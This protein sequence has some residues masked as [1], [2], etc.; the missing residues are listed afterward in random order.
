MRP[1]QKRGTRVNFITHIIYD[2]TANG[3]GKSKGMP[4]SV[5]FRTF[6]FFPICSIQ[7]AFLPEFSPI[8]FG[9]RQLFDPPAEIRRSDI[10][11]LGNDSLAFFQW[12]DAALHSGAERLYRFDTVNRYAP[13]V[14]QFAVIGEAGFPRFGWCGR[15]AWRF[16]GIKKTVYDSRVLFLLLTDFGGGELRGALPLFGHLNVDPD[17]RAVLL[18]ERQRHGEADGVGEL[19]LVMLQLF[20]P[21]AT[22]DFRGADHSA[23]F[24]LDDPDPAPDVGRSG[25][26]FDGLHA[27]DDPSRER[28]A[29]KKTFHGSSTVCATNELELAEIRRRN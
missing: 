8:V 29:D 9:Y 11:Q 20:V 22:G 7:A 1:G 2:K 19:P 5:L 10:L 23:A 14:R 6:S 16:A 27:V 15:C 18:T 28:G 21:F 4:W 25:T 12:L 13:P 24:A 17:D 3:R 26:V